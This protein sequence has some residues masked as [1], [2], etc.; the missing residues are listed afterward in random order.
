M[1][2]RALLI[3]TGAILLAGCAK[4]QPSVESPSGESSPTSTEPVVA[5]GAEQSASGAMIAGLLIATLNLPAVAPAAGNDWLAGL[6]KGELDALAAYAGTTWSSVSDDDEP[7]DDL[8]SELASVLAPEVSVLAPGK[9]D[10]GLVWMAAASSGMKSLET[11]PAWSK[12][13]AAAVPGMALLRSDGL[14]A[15]N[16]I[17]RTG[18][19]AIT[20]ND[21]LVRAQMVASGRAGIGAFRRTDY[22]GGAA[23]VELA[24]PDK[25]GT[26]DPLTLLVNT[27]FAENSPDQV[28]ALNAVVQALDNAELNAMQR[29]V[30]E[31]SQVAEVAKQ[32]LVSKGLI[33]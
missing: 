12:G 2:R 3:G 31:G 7:T 17:Y 28:L 19:T 21:P 6:G 5:V 9:T 4:A 32:W 18:F 30:A 24:D 33:K 1:D 25:V 15:V 10:G 22:L 23:L 8:M 14:T 16:T 26:A 11:L 27:T 29:R 13:K 20:E